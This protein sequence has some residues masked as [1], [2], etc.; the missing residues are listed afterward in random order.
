ML[1]AVF[2]ALANEVVLLL[3]T[4]AWGGGAHSSQSVG[5]GIWEGLAP[6]L[7]RISCHYMAGCLHDGESE[8]SDLERPIGSRRKQ[9]KE[10]DKHTAADRQSLNRARQTAGSLHAQQ[11]AS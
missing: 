7:L 9:A 4:R 2:S 10:R 6:N 11:L 1:T 5:S 3:L 8:R